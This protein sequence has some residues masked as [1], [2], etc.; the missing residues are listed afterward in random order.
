MQRRVEISGLAVV[1][2][3][4]FLFSPCSLLLANQAKPAPRPA[5][6]VVRQGGWDIPGRSLFAKASWESK[7]STVDGVA[8][9]VETLDTLPNTPGRLPKTTPVIFTFIDGDTVLLFEQPSSAWHITRYSTSE[10][11]PFLYTMSVFRCTSE[12]VG[13]AV[14]GG[15]AGGDVFVA[16]YDLNGDGIFETMETPDAVA[17]G[18]LDWKPTVPAW[19]H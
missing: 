17:R 12:K 7:H 13:D 1:V 3:L 6:R 19:V 18:E 2:S 9:R 11:K 15:C 4:L 16:Y 8:I 5:R 14:S 10:G